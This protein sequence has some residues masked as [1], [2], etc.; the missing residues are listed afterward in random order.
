MANGQPIQHV[1]EPEK[2]VPVVFEADVVVAGAGVAGTFA[3]IAA[4]RKGARTVLVDRFGNVGGN[5]GPGM[6][7][8][9]AMVSGQAHPSLGFE[10]TVYPGLYGIGK[11]F[12]NRYARQGGRSIPPYSEANY[13]NDSHV[14]SYVAQ[15]MLEESGVQLL[16]STQVADP[17][18]DGTTV[19]GLYVENK[20]GRQAIPAKVVIDATG[21]AD[22]A[23]RA[24]APILLPK[25]EYNELDGHSPTGQGGYFVL[26]GID[27]DRH[28]SHARQVKPADEDVEWVNERYDEAVAIKHPY[29]V[30]FLRQELE[31][32]GYKLIREIDLGMGPLKIRADTIL[33][34]R[35]TNCAQGRVRPERINRV[36]A[37]DGLHIS[38]L[39]AACRRQIFET[40]QFWRTYVPGFENCSLLCVAPFLGA[41]GGPSIEGEYVL[42]MGDCRE[43]KHFDDVIYLYGEFR[44]LAWT[45]ERGGAKW[46]DVPYRVLLP[47]GIDGLMAAGRC[48][49]GIPDT[50][51]RNRM[52]VKVMGEACGI[53]AAMSASKG[54][55]PKE[56][57]RK[58]LQET[59][60]DAGFYL[61]D[62]HRL[63]G[64]GLV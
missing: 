49:S 41:R 19:K 32:S 3:A 17:I 12:L 48:A 34:M 59:L 11:E 15:M 61:G 8:N 33:P 45:A 5:I 20:S 2:R 24:G 9:G 14:A 35:G 63:K 37:G 56:L 54:I 55:A 42:T 57:D 39:E 27:W 1:S 36:D 18:V 64:L 44:A 6:I 38:M 62:R 22:V 16:L 53:A 13:P 52:A 28:E 7:N 50:L 30:P 31:K 43:G 26:S 51:L 40:V 25:D 58:E 21:E 60:L 23:R 47:K 46:V 29:I 10:C 4:A